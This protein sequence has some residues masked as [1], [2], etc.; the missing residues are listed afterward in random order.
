MKL[1]KELRMVVLQPRDFDD[2]LVATSLAED[3]AQVVVVSNQAKLLD[4]AA[5]ARFAED[6]SSILR[7]SNMCHVGKSEATAGGSPDGLESFGGD[8]PVKVLV[9]ELKAQQV[10]GSQVRADLQFPTG[11][12][13][14]CMS[15]SPVG[16]ANR[17]TSP[18]NSSGKILTPS[19]CPPF[20]FLFALCFVFFL[21]CVDFLRR[22]LRG[23]LGVSLSSLA[24]S[25]SESRAARV[26]RGWR[27]RRPACGSK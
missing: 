13:L 27:A 11:R 3:A 15:T 23:F 1:G 8:E 25:P 5:L 10:D 6:E 4:P 2:A 20:F 14:S 24:S 21:S 7:L 16:T 26:L 22:F 18:S 19:S 9:D 17:L 12:W